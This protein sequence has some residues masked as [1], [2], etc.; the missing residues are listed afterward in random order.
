LAFLCAGRRLAA[1]ALTDADSL[2]I[3]ADPLA[4]KGPFFLIE[5]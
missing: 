2:G 5:S 4:E 3:Q 1:A